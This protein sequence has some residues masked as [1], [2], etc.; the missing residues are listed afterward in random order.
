MSRSPSEAI[1]AVRQFLGNA[2]EGV[3]P[4][5]NH[6]HFNISNVVNI[7]GDG[8]HVSIAYSGVYKD[9]EE[10]EQLLTMCDDSVQRVILVIEG[11]RVDASTLDLEGRS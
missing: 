6:S 10:G 2:E 4:D 11:N 7:P 9:N 5:R 1:Q 8:A 3:V